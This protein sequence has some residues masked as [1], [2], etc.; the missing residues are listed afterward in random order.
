MRKGANL[1]LSDPIMAID[2]VLHIQVQVP[3]VELDPRVREMLEQKVTPGDFT[4]PKV[5][6]ESTA[7]KERQAATEGYD[8]EDEA[9]SQQDR[10]PQVRSMVRC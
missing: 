8:D 2:S 10:S 4:I 7:D 5:E 9:P 6:R 3:V 1:G